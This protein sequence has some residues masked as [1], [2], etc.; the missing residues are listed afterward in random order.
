MKPTLLAIAFAA[1]LLA[2]AQ[3]LPQ[4]SPKGRVEQ[5][6]GLTKVSV[7]YSRPSAKGRAIFGDL[8]TM[9]Q[10]WRLGANGCTT[11][12]FDGPVAIGGVDQKIPA[13][14]YSLFAEPMD[15]A[16]VFHLNKNI[17]LWGTDGYKAEEDVAVWKAE[18]MDNEYTETLTI[19]FDEVKDD[20]ARVD[21]RWEKVRASFIIHADATEQAMANIKKAMA[22]KEIKASTYN[23]CARYCVD[24]GVMLPD[25][26][27]WAQK[28]NGMEKEP[29]YWMLHTLALAQ[30]ANGNYKEATVTAQQSMSLARKDGDNGYVKLN[31][32]KINEWAGK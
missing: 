21:V 18:V 6:V 4:P 19:G 16:W 22:E 20:K 17:E 26:L 29:K 5:I 12:S 11:L 23:R 31:E 13:G 7:D 9:G 32:T 27:G 25:A 28:A 10:L 8:I 24:K 14:T 15:G 2:A 1:P 30:A 3:D